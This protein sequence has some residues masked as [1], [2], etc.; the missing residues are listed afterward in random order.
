MQV[1]VDSLLT[2]YQQNGQGKVIVFVHGWGSNLA[3]FKDLSQ[4]LSQHY[5][6]IALD[7]PGFGTTAPPPTA[8]GL[9]DYALFI[10]KFLLKINAADIY[11]LIGHSNGGAILIR[12][13]AKDILKAEKLVLL[14]SAGIR[15]D[16]QLRKAL[17]RYAAKVAKIAIK[18]LPKS[19]RLKLRKQ[20]YKSIGSD[21][22]VAEHLQ[23]TFK[24]VVGADVLS[25]AAT[26]I[27]PA[28]LVYGDKDTITPVKYGEKFAARIPNS[29][30]EII[31]GAGHFIHQDDLAKAG[32]L[33]EE[34]LR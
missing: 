11:T 17:L 16:Q 27:L 13:I 23:E 29:K 8:W 32:A 21:L 18:P 7:L 20:A 10:H 30:L 22:F 4:Q 24:K 33:I 14:S 25:D 1:I 26:L 9:D 15:N 6:V 34:F 12:A 3:T 28:L 5:N 31:P 19:A 2:N